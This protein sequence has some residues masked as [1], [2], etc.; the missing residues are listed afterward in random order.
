MIKQENIETEKKLNCDRNVWR[1]KDIWHDEKLWQTDAGQKK[2]SLSVYHERGR[3]QKNTGHTK[4]H[5]QTQ[6]WENSP[7]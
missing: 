7:E 2:K 6:N 1:D 5:F 3:Q 4:K